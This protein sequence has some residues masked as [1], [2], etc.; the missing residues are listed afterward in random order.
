MSMRRRAR[1]AGAQIT[2]RRNHKCDRCPLDWHG[3]ISGQRRM[4]STFMTTSK[5]AVLGVLVSIAMSTAAWAQYPGGQSGTRGGAGGGRDGPRPDTMRAAPAVEAPLNAGALVQT[6]LDQIEDELKL[7]PA[8][9]GAWNAYADKVQKLADEV[10]RIRFEA[11]TATPAS[12][13]APQQLDRVATDMRS[14]VA[15]VD[16]IVA[17][18]H[19]FY[20]TL[21]PEQKVVAD[22]RLALP[23]AL[24]ATGVVPAGMSTGRT[25]GN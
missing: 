24:L 16:E 13:S 7:T 22:R 21:T 15:F 14:R 4:T 3:G 5:S 23:L 6:Q 17:L 1:S 10:A 12:T 8:Q 19:A 9:R 20:A 2:Q 25:P 18:G 11:R